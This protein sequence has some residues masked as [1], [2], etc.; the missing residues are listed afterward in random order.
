MR[1]HYTAL[2]ANKAQAVTCM[3]KLKAAPTSL[4]LNMAANG[5]F[6]CAIGLRAVRTLVA[7][8]LKEQ[9]IRFLL[10]SYPQI[11]FFQIALSF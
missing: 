2:T 1:R 8:E 6:A 5:V 3:L 4:L 9:A 10:L 11:L 7:R